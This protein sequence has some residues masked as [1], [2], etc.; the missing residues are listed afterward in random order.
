VT[1]TD[2][3][4]NIFQDLTIRFLEKEVEPFFEAWEEQECMPKSLWKTMGDGVY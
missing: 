1:S 4:F 3:E 2:K